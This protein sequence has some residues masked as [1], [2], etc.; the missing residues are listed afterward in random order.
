MPKK[1][2][3]ILLLISSFSVCE[4]EPLDF[5]PAMPVD[6]LWTYEHR[7]GKEI[8]GRSVYQ[9]SRNKEIQKISEKHQD[10]QGRIVAQGRSLFDLRGRFLE[11]YFEEKGQEAQSQ[12]RNLAG[13]LEMERSQEGDWV[14]QTWPKELALV[15]FPLLGL[16]LQNRV[17]ELK[18]NKQVHLTLVISQVVLELKK[19]GLPENWSQLGLVCELVGNETFDLGTVQIKALKLI[20]KP[21]DSLMASLLPKNRQRMVLLLAQEKPHWVLSFSDGEQSYSLR[22]LKL[23]G[24]NFAMT[25]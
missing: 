12:W 24:P 9:S 11:F 17:E 7:Q 18:K 15:P 4:A 14:R 6:A 10:K 1:F 13:G 20:L 25:P 22:N 3:L 21:A 19:R 8:T 23:R 5:P 16:Y 2:L